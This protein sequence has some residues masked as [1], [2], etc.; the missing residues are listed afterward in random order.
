MSHDA[1]ADLITLIAAIA[2]SVMG[3][4]YRDFRHRV[5]HLE[6]NQKMVLIALYHLSIGTA[7]PE[8]VKEEIERRFLNGRK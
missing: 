6:D 4:L 8:H 7:L 1:L 5:N 3:V 2:M